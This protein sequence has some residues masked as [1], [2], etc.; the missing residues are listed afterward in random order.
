MK[1]LSLVLALV[2]VLTC[3][4]LAACGGDEDT[5]SAATSST[6]ATSS[7]P[8]E[9]SKEAVST[10][11]SEEAPAES[12]DA[13]TESSEEAPAESSDAATEVPT[14]PAGENVAS[15][16]AY[17]TSK[18]YRQGGAEV[19]WAYSEDAPEAYPDT[20]GIELTD[21]VLPEDTDYTNAAWVGLH[22][23]TPDA[24]EAGYSWITID[25][26]EAKAINYIKLYAGSANTGA[27]QGVGIGAPAGVEFFGSNDGAEWTSLGVANITDG[28]YYS[29]AETG[30]VAEVQYVQARLFTGGW[31]FVTEMEV[32]AE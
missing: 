23:G 24:T 18:L 6:A 7:K 27:D 26:G 1:K 21:G 8:A 28:D 5:S 13:A 32:Y 29:V 17:T 2:L 16:A 15:G 10:E 30:T 25:L 19:N 4:V 11:S 14:A 22:D 20:D 9:E 3:A 12:S 31:A